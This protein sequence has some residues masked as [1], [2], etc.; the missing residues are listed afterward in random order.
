MSKNQH[1]VPVGSQWGIRGEG[2]S[3]LTGLFDKQSDAIGTGREIAQNQHGI[4]LLSR[5]FTC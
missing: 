3:R 5:N 4:I 2:N 1:I